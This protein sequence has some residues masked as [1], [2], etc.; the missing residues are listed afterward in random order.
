MMLSASPFI[1]EKREEFH[2]SNC[3]YYISGD[4][5]TSCT[6]DSSCSPWVADGGT[7]PS[8]RF[9]GTFPIGKTIAPRD[10]IFMF[11]PRG[12]R[13]GCYEGATQVS[14]SVS[15]VVRNC[16]TYCL[17]YNKLEIDSLPPGCCHGV[18]TCFI[19]HYSGH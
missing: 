8:D 15:D 6:W 16:S 2:F 7:C 5:Q 18:I 4:L 17:I 1:W 10:Q 13:G 19:M 11:G 3:T 9:S 14:E 12:G